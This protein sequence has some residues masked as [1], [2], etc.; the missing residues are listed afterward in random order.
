[1]YD[2]NYDYYN[3]LG[4]HSGKSST[5]DQVRKQYR[6]QALKYH[7][8]KNKNRDSEETFKNILKAYRCL[9]DANLKVAYDSEKASYII[10]NSSQVNTKTTPATSGD[11]AGYSNTTYNE[12]AGRSYYRNNYNSLFSSSGDKAYNHHDGYKSFNSRPSKP[13]PKSAFEVFNADKFNPSNKKNYT[14]PSRKSSPVPETCHESS[15]FSFSSS[16][17]FE[18]QFH[19]AEGNEIEG[20]INDYMN[21]FTQYKYRFDNP[22]PIRETAPL[23]PSQSNYFTS[24]EPYFK[25]HTVPCQPNVVGKKPSH[26]FS[27]TETKARKPSCSNA[28]HS[29]N[30]FSNKRD[31]VNN[32]RS[33]MS[34]KPKERKFKTP[35]SFKNHSQYKNTFG[36]FSLDSYENDLEREIQQTRMGNNKNVEPQVWA[37]HRYSS[38]PTKNVKPQACKRDIKVPKS[39]KKNIQKKKSIGVERELNCWQIKDEKLPSNDIGGNFNMSGIRTNLPRDIYVK[40]QKGGMGHSPEIEPGKDIGFDF[41]PYSKYAELDLSSDSE[42]DIKC[43]QSS[44]SN[45]ESDDEYCSATDDDLCEYISDLKFKEDTNEEFCSDSGSIVS[46]TGEEFEQSIDEPSNFDAIERIIVDLKQLLAAP[47]SMYLFNHNTMSVDIKLHLSQYSKSYNSYI[48]ELNAKFRDFQELLYDDDNDGHKY[49][50]DDDVDIYEQFM[51]FFE[52]EIEIKDEWNEIVRKNKKY[53]T[54]CNKLLRQK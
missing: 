3:I 44:S 48:R 5:P 2:P 4:L 23:K 29:R 8:D 35:K 34:T 49:D 17:T 19:H 28:F 45:N 10:K 11:D 18:P 21:D 7:P 46:S 31:E 22:N 15:F 39:V 54:E 42:V 12:G 25:S 1:M 52:S 32:S 53:I 20:L 24:G 9:S 47:P 43:F 14:E 40:S 6:I 38:E 26:V 16:T 27:K 36:L 30:K 33:E 13:K 50:N 41:H 51:N 37:F